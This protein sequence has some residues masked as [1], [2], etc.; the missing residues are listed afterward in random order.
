MNAEQTQENYTKK[1]KEKKTRIMN[2]EQSQKFQTKKWSEAKGTKTDIHKRT[3]LYELE[4]F[5]SNS[6][7]VEYIKTFLLSNTYGYFPFVIISRTTQV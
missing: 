3:I 7:I 2:Y 5:A 6:Q 1:R 4:K